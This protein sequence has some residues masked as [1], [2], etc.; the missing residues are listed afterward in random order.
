[1]MKFRA[2]EVFCVSLTTVFSFIFNIGNSQDEQ[3]YQRAWIS[4]SGAGNA[5][6][7]TLLAF[8][9]GATAGVDSLLDAPKLPGNVILSLATRIGL[10]DFSIQALPPLT[11]DVDIQLSIV[12]IEGSQTMK[13][14]E[15]INF[16]DAGQIILEDVKLGIIHNLRNASYDYTFNPLTDS[17]RFIAHLKPSPDLYS[18][19]ESCLGNDGSILI[20]INSEASWDL[21]FANIDSSGITTFPEVAGVFELGSLIPGIYRLVF[22]NEYGSSFEQAIEILP[23]PG[24]PFS[25]SPD[26]DNIDIHEPAIVFTA[27][28]ENPDSIAWNMGDGSFVGDSLIFAYDYPSPGV[29]NV[30]ATAYKDACS[31]SAS[32]AITISDIT[33]SVAVF[34]ASDLPVYPNPASGFIYCGDDQA[35]A[36]R[37]MLFDLQGRT[38]LETNL[39]G[40]EMISLEG[41]SNGIYH[42]T[43][44]LAKET[45]TFMVFVK[46]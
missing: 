19:Q 32:I 46:H 24:F 45:R 44:I 29:Y 26:R 8:K 3:I 17:L 30:T 39:A 22:S 23:F 15:L 9:Q 38:L 14:E 20:T 21:S 33:T 2:K 28:C 1:M 34:G 42:A 27:L 31:Y 40:R 5:F 35:G 7:E 25:I 37:F 41:I 36:S 13:V 16:P 10:R 18:V 12:A 4:V 43:L 6:N 11:Y